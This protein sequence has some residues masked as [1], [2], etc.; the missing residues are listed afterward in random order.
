ME[1]IKLPPTHKERVSMCSIDATFRRISKR[2]R[3]MR[4]NHV[5]YIYWGDQ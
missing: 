1:H 2:V 5:T 3:L 4:R